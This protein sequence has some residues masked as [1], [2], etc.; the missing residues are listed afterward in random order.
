MTATAIDREMFSSWVE[1]Q[2]R[3]EEDA[4]YMEHLAGECGGNCQHCQDELRAEAYQKEDSHAY[5]I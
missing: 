4:A 1:R 5:Q 2:I 3:S